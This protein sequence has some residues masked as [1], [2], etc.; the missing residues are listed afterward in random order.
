[1]VTLLDG[2]SLSL[3]RVKTKPIYREM[4]DNLKGRTL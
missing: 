2:I 4:N 1:M 3:N